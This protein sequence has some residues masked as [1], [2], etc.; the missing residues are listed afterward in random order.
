MVD[1]LKP[2]RN[3][4]DD[5]E[6][7]IQEAIARGEFDNLPGEGRPIDLTENPFVPA[8]WRLA[9]KTLKDNALAPEFVLRLKAIEDL[10]AEMEKTRTEAVLRRL[11]TKLAE[12]VD[13]LNSSLLREEHFRASSL[14]LPPVDVEAEVT[15]HLSRGA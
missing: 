7:K 5:V 15:W 14:Q 11:A 12:E 3:P 6:E 9:Y 1:P 13:A 8:E 2:P 4:L 10:R